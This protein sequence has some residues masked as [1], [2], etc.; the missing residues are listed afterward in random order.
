M[1]GLPT[2]RSRFNPTFSRRSADDFGQLDD[3]GPFGLRI[4]DVGLE[5]RLEGIARLIREEDVSLQRVHRLDDS[6]CD[7]QTQ[8][9]M[10]QDRQNWLIIPRL[11]QRTF[12]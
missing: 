7:D 5:A 1:P 2:G 8:R 4:L 3:L 10:L 12:M 11:W 9:K 6:R